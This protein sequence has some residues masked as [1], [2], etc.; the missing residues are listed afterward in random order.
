[1]LSLL[2]FFRRDLQIAL[3]YRAAFVFQVT[4]VVL[5][6]GAFYFLARM[7]GP[8]PT[9]LAPYGG[10]YFAFVLIGMALTT[11]F[12]FS[13]G[14][15]TQQIREGQ[16]NG[17]LEATLLSPT[18]LPTALLAMYLYPFLWNLL[19]L[20]LYFLAGTLLGLSW[21]D[22]NLWGVFFIFLV[23]LPAFGGI[24]ILSAA[25]ILLLKRGDPITW[26][27]ASLSWLLSGTLYPV[28][29]LPEWLRLLAQLLPLTHALEGARKA[30]LQGAGLYELL[31][32]LGT[33][34]VFSAILLPLS[35]LAFRWAVERARVVGTLGHY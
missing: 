34:L 21:K 6:A 9:A 11:Y 30:L 10:N 24:G 28:T 5:T 29:V 3:S 14:T 13:L 1:M 2:A 17:T 16:L 15:F 12:T 23:S 4:D 22:A 25:F 26:I 27:L 8:D 18:G 33:L 31:P 7:V 20:L 19:E 32:E 35:L